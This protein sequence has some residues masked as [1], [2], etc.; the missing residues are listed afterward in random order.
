MCVCVCVCLSSQSLTGLPQWLSGKEA[1]CNAGD[2]GSIPGSGRCPGGGHG[3]PLQ[4]SCLENPMDRGGWLQ[5]IFRV[6]KS[7]GRLKARGF[8]TNYLYVI[9]TTITSELSHQGPYV[10]DKKQ[11]DRKRKFLFTQ[12]LPGFKSFA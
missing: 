7:Q 10:L 12:S 4:D 3:N 1:T 5:F 11:W 2:V 9:G 8:L 6:A